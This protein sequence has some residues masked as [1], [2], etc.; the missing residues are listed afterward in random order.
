[1]T[2]LVKFKASINPHGQVYLPTEIRAELATRLLEILGNAR[3]I[4]LYPRGTS[5]SEVLRS[6]E[7]VMFDLKHR[8]EL[9]KKQRK[10]DA[11]SEQTQSM[12]PT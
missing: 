3:A 10:R 5:P 6:L 7:V 2:E 12:K 9:A 4:V 11:R 1:V 8:Q